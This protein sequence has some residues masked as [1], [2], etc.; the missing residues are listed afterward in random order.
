MIVIRTC[1]RTLAVVPSVRDRLLYARRDSVPAEHR[2]V[3]VVIIGVSSCTT[4]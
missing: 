1:R 4:D 2:R 3:G